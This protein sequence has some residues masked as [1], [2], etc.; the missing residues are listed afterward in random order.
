MKRILVAATMVLA[1]SALMFAQ[2]GLRP[3]GAAP[4]AIERGQTGSRNG[5]LKEALNLTDAQVE[6]IQGLR[7]TRQ[8]RAMAIQAEMRQ[9]REAL[10][11]QLNAAQP[12]ATTV[13]NAAIALHATQQRLQAEQDWFMAELKKL[14]TGEQQ[15]KLDELIAA[16]STLLGPL[17]VGPGPG[18]GRGGYRR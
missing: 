14:L 11:A 18:G 17:G 4:G 9:K 15:Q 10:E 2:R 1:S 3:A 8:E 16:R 12:N 13:G 6:A 7:A 5:A